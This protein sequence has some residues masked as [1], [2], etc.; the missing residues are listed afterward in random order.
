M[1][2]QFLKCQQTLT[3]VILHNSATNK[4]SCPKH[5]GYGYR[6]KPLSYTYSVQSIGQITCTDKP[7]EYASLQF[8]QFFRPI[9]LDLQ[10]ISLLFRIN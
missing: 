1:E 2:S 8:L 7:R 6:V 10:P 5:L 9:V 3:S 4:Y